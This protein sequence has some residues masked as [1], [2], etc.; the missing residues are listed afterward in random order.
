MKTLQRPSLM[1]GSLIKPPI[2]PELEFNITVNSVSRQ[3]SLAQP[4]SEG[5]KNIVDIIVH[6]M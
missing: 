5:S 4:I 3:T 6:R 2:S 1:D